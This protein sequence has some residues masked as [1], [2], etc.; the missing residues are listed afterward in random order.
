[1]LRRLITLTLAAALGASAT[2][3]AQARIKQL[4][5][6]IVEYHSADVRAVA[7]YEYCN[8][9]EDAERRR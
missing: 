5:R 4:G 1:M 6:A 9:V 3:S 2:I 8:Q 7:S